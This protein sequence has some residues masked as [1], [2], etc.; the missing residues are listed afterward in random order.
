MSGLSGI[1]S[2]FS[3][4]YGQL[5]K[6]VKIIDAFAFFQITT[7]VIQVCCFDFQCAVELMTFSQMVYML[8][9]GTFPF[10]SFLSGFAAAFISFILTGT[11]G[12][13]L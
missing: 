6:R 2:E 8:M 10:N 1:L 4:S 12:C 7:A 13:L 5:P 3:T 9:V 11:C